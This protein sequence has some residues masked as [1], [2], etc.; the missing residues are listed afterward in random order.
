MGKK[1]R[2]L[3][4]PDPL[5]RRAVQKATHN[6]KSENTV[7]LAGTLMRNPAVAA[8]LSLTHV[9]KSTIRSFPYLKFDHYYIRMLLLRF[10]SWR[11][12]MYILVKYRARARALSPGH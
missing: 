4:L 2:H 1:T 8:P 6:G 9:M 12:V 5:S 7:M 11:R 3:L 10:H